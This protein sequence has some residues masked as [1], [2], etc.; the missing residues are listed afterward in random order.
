MDERQDYFFQDL[1]FLEKIAEG[2]FM[3]LAYGKNLKAGQKKNNPKRKRV[4]CLMEV[5]F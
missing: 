1:P 5:Q 2:V 3:I 4:I